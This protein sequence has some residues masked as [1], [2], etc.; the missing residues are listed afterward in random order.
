M[1]I[2]F[3]KRKE[4]VGTPLGVRLRLFKPEGTSPKEVDSVGAI[5]V[6]AVAV[7]VAVA[8][9][10]L[11]VHEEVVSLEVAGNRVVDGL[12]A[13]VVQEGGDAVQTHVDTPTAEV[14]YSMVEVDVNDVAEIFFD[15]FLDGL[16]ATGRPGHKSSRL[17]DIRRFRQFHQYRTFVNKKKVRKCRIVW[18]GDK[19]ELRSYSDGVAIRHGTGFGE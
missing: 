9:D 19:H 10:I 3:A 13:S 1:L 11:L 4:Q 2:L 17:Q 7:A 14:E 6:V 12:D 16:L 5:T 8:V 15:F 18:K